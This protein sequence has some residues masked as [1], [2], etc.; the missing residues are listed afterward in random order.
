MEKPITKEQKAIH[1]ILESKISDVVAKIEEKLEQNPDY[2]HYSGRWSVTRLKDWDLEIA[3]T[4]RK[5]V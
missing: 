1:N 2:A 5:R 4:I 3:V